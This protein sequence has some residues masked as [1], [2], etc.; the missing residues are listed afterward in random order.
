[1]GPKGDPRGRL[2]IIGGNPG[3]SFLVL[4]RGGE[5]DVLEC[6][7]IMGVKPYARFV[8]EAMGCSLMRGDELCCSG[9]EYCCAPGSD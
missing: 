2:P 1:M 7:V 3:A 9:I 4:G 6:W 5:F 8:L